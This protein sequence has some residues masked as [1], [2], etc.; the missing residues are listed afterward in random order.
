VWTGPWREFPFPVEAGHLLAFRRAIGAT[1][2]PGGFAPPTFAAAT[3]HFDPAYTR[4]PPLGRGWG[5][6]LPESH[7][8]VGQHFTY[9]RP[10]RTGEQ[11]VAR[12]GPGEVREKTGRS[13]RLRFVE[14][15]TELRD[16]T[17]ALVLVMRWV[18]VHAERTH[19]ELTNAQRA[20][21]ADAP[22]PEAPPDGRPVV[23]AT[24][25]SRTQFVMYAGASGDFHPLHHDD[26]L[27][28]RHGY[29]SVFCPGMLTMALSCRAL[30][31]H[32]PVETLRS[33]SSRYRAQVW[34]GDTL[35]AHVVTVEP[36]EPGSV[37]AVRVVTV[38]QHGA[39]V[40]DTVVH[41][42]A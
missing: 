14:E 42:S 20:E 11:L 13:G 16:E 35:T 1:T 3:D 21:R 7:L 15:R 30:D 8:H 36:T 32:L 28:R 37:R 24:D 41:A 10:L 34:P 26:D 40:L 39:A 23:V 22:A 17:G 27:A 25:L 33:V 18:D 6:G 19:G 9:A 2:A 38:N 4:R 29:P 31:D 12:R 5:A